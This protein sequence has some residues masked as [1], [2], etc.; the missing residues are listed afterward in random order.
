M[1]TNFS[2][3]LKNSDII[4]KPVG[5]QDQ[6]LTEHCYRVMQFDVLVLN[7]SSS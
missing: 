7:V 3:M 2:A 5:S 1:P 6:V 4:G